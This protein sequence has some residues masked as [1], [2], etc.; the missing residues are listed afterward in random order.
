MLW[1]KRNVK[2]TDIYKILG[3]KEYYDTYSYTYTYLI[4]YQSYNL[5]SLL[6]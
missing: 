4:I 5:Q 3:I 2:E 1:G 6:I